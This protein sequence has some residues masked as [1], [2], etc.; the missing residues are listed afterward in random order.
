MIGGE[1]KNRLSAYCESAGRKNN[2]RGGKITG[3]EE[4]YPA[5]RIVNRRGGEITVGEEK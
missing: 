4:K 3:G 5:V 1:E 2:R